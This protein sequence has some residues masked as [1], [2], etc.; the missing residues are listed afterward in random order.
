[1]NIVKTNPEYSE[2][3]QRVDLSLHITKKMNISRTSKLNY[4]L[5]YLALFLLLLF[6]I[7]IIYP[8]VNY[9]IVQKF[10]TNSETFYNFDSKQAQ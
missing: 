2:N 7:I 9:F 4:S 5:K 6:A 10:I 3:T 8:V 1:M